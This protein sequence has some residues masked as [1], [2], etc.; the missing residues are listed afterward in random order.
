MRGFSGDPL[1]GCFKMDEVSPCSPNPCGKNS[2]CF[3]YDSEL[4]PHCECNE[5]FFGWPPNCSEGCKSDNDCKKTEICNDKSKCEEFCEPS[6]C[7]KNSVCRVDKKSRTINCS[8]KEGYIPQ[9]NVGC[10][11]KASSEDEL[12]IKS[13]DDNCSGKCGSRASCH[14]F[15]GKFECSCS[16]ETINDHKNPFNYCGEIIVEP[17][18]YAG[19]LSGRIEAWGGSPGPWTRSTTKKLIKVLW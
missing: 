19:V 18:L 15:K 5:G 9:E 7:G 1:E 4:G 17:P 11:L 6:R 3:E 14:M 10:R 16:L 12:S 2:Q 8:C 13:L